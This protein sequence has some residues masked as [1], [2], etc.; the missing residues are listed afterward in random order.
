MASFDDL[1]PEYSEADTLERAIFTLMEYYHQSN[2]KTA[3]ALNARLATVF[4][5]NHGPRAYLTAWDEESKA[6]ETLETHAKRRA[7][8]TDVLRPLVSDV[9]F[10]AS[11]TKTTV[12]VKEMRIT[13]KLR[14]EAIKT[15][16]DCVLY[17]DA[18]FI[19]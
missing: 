7:Y 1:L 12:R 15:L 6:K 3:A 5:N 14:D 17:W 4:P 16:C 18:H 9:D 19:C 10:I 8:W 2:G 11:L 13:T